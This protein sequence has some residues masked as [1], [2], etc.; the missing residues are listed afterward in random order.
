[1]NHHE[2][3]ARR[4]A[5]KSLILRTRSFGEA[6]PLLIC[7]HE[8]GRAEKRASESKDLHLF[9]HHERSA[10]LLF[11]RQLCLHL[12]AIHHSLGKIAELFGGVL[13]AFEVRDQFAIPVNHRRVQGV[14]E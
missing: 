2:R 7:H 9:C 8:R 11:L 13:I 5:S 6:Q 1:M 14:H 3:R 10:R 4:C 12:W